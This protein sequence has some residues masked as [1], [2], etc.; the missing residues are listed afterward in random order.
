[1][2]GRRGRARYWHACR[3]CPALVPRNHSRCRACQPPRKSLESWLE[4]FWA[5]PLPP[6]TQ[7]KLAMRDLPYLLDQF[8]TRRGPAYDRVRNALPN[9]GATD[10][11]PHP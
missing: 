1:M 11:D 5:E 4:E 10:D 9:P 6:D 8:L 2:P 3:F 7:H